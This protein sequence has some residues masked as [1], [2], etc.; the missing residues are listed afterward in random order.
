MLAYWKHVAEYYGF[1][2]V[3]GAPCGHC[4]KDAI[5][6]VKGLYGLTPAKNFGPLALKASAGK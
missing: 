4:L 1:D 3:T 6:V 5:R 2:P